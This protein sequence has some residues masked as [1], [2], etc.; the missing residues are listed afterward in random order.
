M[1]ALIIIAVLLILVG[2]VYVYFSHTHTQNIRR[3]KVANLKELLR[4]L[5]IV[6]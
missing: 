5:D 6:R 1:S 2:I 4:L 3:E